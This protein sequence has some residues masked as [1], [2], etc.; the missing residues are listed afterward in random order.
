V[1]RPAGCRLSPR[2]DTGWPETVLPPRGAS[3]RDLEALEATPRI[4]GPQER[5]VIAATTKQADRR[6]TSAAS[7]S[8]S[9]RT[10]T[11]AVYAAA[12]CRRQGGGLGAG[13]N[14]LLA[15]PSAVERVERRRRAV[16]GCGDAPH[17]ARGLSGLWRPAPAGD[18][19]GDRPPL[20]AGRVRR[21]ASG[22]L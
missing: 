6:L 5:L 22:K 7:S 9:S 2:P 19:D 15:E 3:G 20:P 8:L 16:A 17:R 13:F 12:Q 11:R 1:I 4:Q 21:M 14:G 18:P 10:A